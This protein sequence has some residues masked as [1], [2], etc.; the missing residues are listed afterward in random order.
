MGILSDLYDFILKLRRQ[1]LLLNDVN[2]MASLTRLVQNEEMAQLGYPGIIDYKNISYKDQDRLGNLSQWTKREYLGIPDPILEKIEKEWPD[3]FIDVPLCNM[4][5]DASSKGWMMYD[6]KWSANPASVRLY[7]IPTLKTGVWSVV[8][9]VGESF[10]SKS[11][12]V[13]FS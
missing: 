3:V 12:K 8:G 6:S 1:K 13:L 9:D 5:T 11:K 4:R 2:F 7:H 10:R